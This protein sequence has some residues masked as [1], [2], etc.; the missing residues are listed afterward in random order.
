MSGSALRRKSYQS[1]QEEAN[2]F[3]P[4]HWENPDGSQVPAGKWEVM[5]KFFTPLHQARPVKEA[6]KTDSP[7]QDRRWARAELFSTASSSPSSSSAWSS[8]PWS[9]EA[10]IER[11]TFLVPSTMLPAQ[12]SKSCADLSAPGPSFPKGGKNFQEVPGLSRRHS[13]SVDRLAYRSQRTSAEERLPKVTSLERSLPD[14]MLAQQRSQTLTVRATS[15]GILKNGPSPR[16]ELI[17]KA[18]S[19][20]AITAKSAGKTALPLRKTQGEGQVSGKDGQ[21]ERVKGKE[22]EPPGRAQVKKRYMEEKNRFS[23]FLNEITRQVL[24]PSTLSCLGPEHLQVSP[25][26]V[27]KKRQSSSTDSSGSRD[28]KSRGSPT[29]S[30]PERDGGSQTR[31]SRKRGTSPDSCSGS[32]LPSQTWQS[33]SSCPRAA[34]SGTKSPHQQASTG[35]PRRRDDSPSPQHSPLPTWQRGRPDRAKAAELGQAKFDTYSSFPSTG[36]DHAPPQQCMEFSKQRQTGSCAELPVCTPQKRP[37]QHDRQRKTD[38]CEEASTYN[39]PPQHE[40][41][42]RTEAREGQG[43]SGA[44]MEQRGGDPSD[45]MSMERNPAA[46]NQ[47]RQVDTGNASRTSKEPD[48]EPHATLPLATPDALSC[49]MD[50]V[51]CDSL[52]SRGRRPPGQLELRNELDFLKERFSR[53]QEE[54][55]STQLTNH[56]LEEKLQIIAQTMA[57]ERLSRNERIADLLERLIAAQDSPSGLGTSNTSSSPISIEKHPHLENQGILCQ[58]SSVDMPLV[59]PPL[60]FMDMSHNN[61]SPFHPESSLKVNKLGCIPSAVLSAAETPKPEWKDMHGYDPFLMQEMEKQLEVLKP[62]P[63][64][65]TRNT[66]FSPWK[67]HPGVHS[68]SLEQFHISME[69]ECSLENM[70]QSDTLLVPQLIDCMPETMEEHSRR[71]VSSQ[72]GSSIEAVPED[73]RSNASGGTSLFSSDSVTPSFIQHS[74]LSSSLQML[75]TFG[76]SESSGDDLQEDWLRLFMEKQPKKKEG[77][78]PVDF[79]SAQKI[80]DSLVNTQLEEKGSP[81]TIEELRLSRHQPGG[82]SDVEYKTYKVLAD[83]CEPRGSTDQTQKTSY[84]TRYSPNATC[85]PGGDLVIDY[86]CRVTTDAGYATRCDQNAAYPARHTYDCGYPA[87]VRHQ[88]IGSLDAMSRP[89]NAS[90]P[91]HQPAM[92]PGIGYPNPC[93]HGRE[94]QTNCRPEQL[95]NQGR[96]KRNKPCQGHGSGSRPPLNNPGLQGNDFPYNSSLSRTKAA[97]T[98]STD[99]EHRSSYP[100]DSTLL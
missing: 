59:A 8:S 62:T 11:E 33:G 93:T 44:T 45:H 89:I 82:G 98:A 48:R 46:S 32:S 85:P 47:E 37:S 78:A 43:R 71:H 7:S 30:I 66:A 92:P 1:A 55:S 73:Q 9:S 53:L 84:H 39:Q 15:K 16:S 80:L 67:Q 52:P 76:N 36:T 24:S 27:K 87:D 41:K 69:S 38:S 51:H 64:T 63:N 83:D 70:T 95:Q 88:Q 29:S 3:S 6:K 35:A 19:M 40:G 81:P 42:R 13:K 100:A 18:K 90:E 25:S 68:P 97:N 58:A 72:A 65:V 60:P 77:E 94:V 31:P 49:P 5:E 57:S 17:R 10:S 91:V 75:A 14:A 34:S 22:A 12:H 50:A 4:L 96:P 21:K 61:K 54:Y 28:S 2:C 20:E 26:S 23:Q 74:F 86:E 79:R 56:F 99:Q